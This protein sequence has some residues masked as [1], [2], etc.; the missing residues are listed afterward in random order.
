MELKV[1][2]GMWARVS[3]GSQAQRFGPLWSLL[4]M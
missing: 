3:R 2:L 1:R 4:R